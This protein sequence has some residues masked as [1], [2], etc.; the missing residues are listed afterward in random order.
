MR[1]G[2]LML[3]TSLRDLTSTVTIEAL[4]MGLP[5][6]CLDHCGF[7]EVV[8]ESCGI[9]IPVTTPREVV[10]GFSRRSRNSREMRRSADG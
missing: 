9:K 10:E 1:Q 6:V 2:H 7:A 5:I 8:D 4:S 3:I